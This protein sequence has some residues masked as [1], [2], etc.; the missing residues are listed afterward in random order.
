MP[1][2]HGQVA[3][4]HWEFFT[5]SLH[6][7]KH[8]VSFLNHQDHKKKA[9]HDATIEVAFS[10]RSKTIIYEGEQRADTS[11]HVPYYGTGVDGNLSS[12]PISILC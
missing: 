3:P 9:S 10:N 2:V 11:T 5:V 8:V 7:P 6:H 12:S 4:S 1:I